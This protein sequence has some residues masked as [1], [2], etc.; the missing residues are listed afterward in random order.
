MWLTLLV[1]S[2]ALFSPEQPKSTASQRAAA[3]SRSSLTS[4]L[5]AAAVC[6]CSAWTNKLIT[7]KDHASVQLNIGHLNEEGVYT[8]Q[9]TTFALAG[10]VRA[11]V[12]MGF[13]IHLDAMVGCTEGGL[14]CA[15][16]H[17]AA[18]AAAS[19]AAAAHGSQFGQQQKQGATAGQD[20]PLCRHSACY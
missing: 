5:F 3:R 4:L 1:G 18:T 19:A 12:R 6:G 16:Q 11:Q 8:G 13:Y 20:K 10:K 14:C 9:F 7:A 17:Q 2:H 15:V